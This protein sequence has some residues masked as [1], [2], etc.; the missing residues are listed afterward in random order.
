MSYPIHLIRGV[1]ESIS[2][3]FETLLVTSSMSRFRRRV[4]ASA[5]GVFGFCRTRRSAADLCTASPFLAVRVQ[6]LLP[7]KADRAM[8]HKAY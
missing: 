7:C 6:C 4:C 3:F 2:R 8:R 5:F 1:F